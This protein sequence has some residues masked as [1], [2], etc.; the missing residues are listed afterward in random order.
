ME[1]LKHYDIPPTRYNGKCKC[2]RFLSILA[3][4]EWYADFGGSVHFLTG[5]NG[6]VYAIGN[7]QEPI[8]H[9]PDCGKARYVHKV[10]GVFNNEIKCNAKCEGAHGH[11]C[12]CQCG[13]KNHGA[14]WGC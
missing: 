8:A 12:E 10:A 7:A 1:T 11:D 6:A 3:T 4:D 13:G 14:A 9:C 5:V 2:G